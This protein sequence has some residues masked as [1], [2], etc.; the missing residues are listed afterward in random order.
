M[1]DSH[2]EEVTAVQFSTIIEPFR[3]KAVE[4]M[5]QTT[6]EQR[7]AALVA[8][9]YNPFKLRAEDVLID[10]LTDSGTG[11]MS[12]AQWAGMQ[13]GDESTPGARSL[14]VFEAAVREITGFTA[15]H[16]HPPGPCRRA[17][18]L[19]LGGASGR[20]GAQQQP[21]RHHA[22]QHGGTG[23]RGAGPRHRGGAASPTL[24]APFKGNMDVAALEAVLEEHAGR[25]AAW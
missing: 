5:R 3:I 13:R 14:F 15:H 4:P 23:R 16:P 11:A 10:L 18:P 9:G 20:R 8:A 12:S 25:D 1:D 19:R 7:E 21:L 6:R 24:A 22:R 2:A 17:D